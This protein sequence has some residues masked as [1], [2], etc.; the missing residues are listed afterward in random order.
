MSFSN[1]EQGHVKEAL[2]PRARDID[3]LVRAE[4]QDPFA[5]LGPHGDGAGGQSIRAYLPDA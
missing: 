1:K 3:A 4:H 5:I 2:L